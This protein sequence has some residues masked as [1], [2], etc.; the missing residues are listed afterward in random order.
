[1][2][3]KPNKI[4]NLGEHR[5]A[6][7]EQ[8]QEGQKM[9]E[10]ELESPQTFLESAYLPAAIEA[11]NTSQNGLSIES[12]ALERDIGDE[13][14]PVA[15]TLKVAFSVPSTPKYSVEHSAAAFITMLSNDR[16]EVRGTLLSGYP[17]ELTTFMVSQDDHCKDNVLTLTI[18][19]KSSVRG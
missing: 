19:Q 18:Y 2:N 13:R 6:R 8:A 7:L 15:F 12:Y 4:I 5:Q 9:L 17:S 11:Y 14:D 10:S 16:Q 1:M 3:E